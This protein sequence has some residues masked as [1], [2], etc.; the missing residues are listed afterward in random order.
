MSFEDSFDNTIT[1]TK[2]EVNVDFSKE[3]ESL[4][5]STKRSIKQSIV[6]TVRSDIESD[7]DA[8]RSSVSGKRWKGLSKEYKE[9]KKKDGKGT[10]A[11][12]QLEGDMLSNLRIK[13]IGDKLQLKIKNGLQKKKAFNHITADTMPIQRNFLPNEGET[14]RSGI[15]RDIKRTIREGKRGGE[16]QEET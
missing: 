5:P 16:D 6:D 10:K 2:I 9:Q 11:N 14:F 7:L 13:F 1:K 15:L 3:F 12:L 8:Q 4:D